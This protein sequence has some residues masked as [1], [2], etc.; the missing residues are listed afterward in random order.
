MKLMAK[1]LSDD[2]DYECEYFECGVLACIV[3]FRYEN[4]Y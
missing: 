1:E 3:I 4:Y 2:Y